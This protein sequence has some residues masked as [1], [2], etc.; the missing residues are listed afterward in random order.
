MFKFNSWLKFRKI[1]LIFWLKI[2]QI[3][4]ILFR[5]K[6][7]NISSIDEKVIFI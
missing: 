3:Y 6:N 1:K 7:N 5:N 4:M 2:L